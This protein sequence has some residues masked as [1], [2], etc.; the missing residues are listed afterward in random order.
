[1]RIPPLLG[2]PAA[3][4][5]VDLDQFQLGG[6]RSWTRT[7]LGLRD[8]YGPFVL[9]YLE[10]RRADRGLA[11]QQSTSGRSCPMTSPA[12]TRHVLP[13]LRP[14]PLASYLAGLGL[15]RVIGE[16]AD[17]AATAAWT[18]DGLVIGTTVPDIAAWLADEYVPTPVLSP[19]NN[20]SGFGP[21]DKEPVR[22]LDA[23]L[24]HPSPRLAPFRDAIQV[25][26][27]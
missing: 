26:S 10:T 20:G 14:E 8:R 15:I 12:M 22:A 25:R 9:A 18:P 6:D 19:W 13:G 1:M 5:T 27:T 16:Q 17:P 21:K 7:V 23:L 2:Q 11:R 3:E 4:L 24:A